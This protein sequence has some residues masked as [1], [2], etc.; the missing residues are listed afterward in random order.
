MSSGQRNL[1][2]LCQQQHVVDRALQNLGD[3]DA[4]QSGVAV[5]DDRNPL[6]VAQPAEVG[7]DRRDGGYARGPIH[8]LKALSVFPG[9]LDGAASGP[10][11]GLERLEGRMLHCRQPPV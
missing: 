7:D 9:Q 4:G 2:P 5:Q 1:C 11:Q 8:Q 6:F 3:L 10:Y